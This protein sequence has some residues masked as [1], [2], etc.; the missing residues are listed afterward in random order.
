MEC[1]LK[2]NNYLLYRKTDSYFTKEILDQIMVLERDFAGKVIE[3][4]TSEQS[5]SSGDNIYLCGDIYGFSLPIDVNIFIIEELSTYNS[6]NSY[7][8]LVKLGEVPINI[9]N[10]G[11]LCRQVF[12]N[13]LFEKIMEKHCF[14]ELTESNKGTV[15]LRQGIYLS[16]VNTYEKSM[17][18]NLLRCSTNLKGPTENFRETDHLIINKTNELAKRFFNNPAKLNHVLAQVYRNK[19]EETKEKRAGIKAH[20]DKTKDMNENGLMAFVS[21]YDGSHLTISNVKQSGYDFVY[22]KE[23]VLSSLFFKLKKDVVG[24]YKSEFNVVLYPGSVLF[25]PL[26]TNRIYTHETKTSVLPI[27]KIPERMGY[28]VRCSKTV[29]R[30]YEEENATY[31]VNGEKEE[32]MHEMTEDEIELIRDLYFKENV[33]SEKVSYPLILSSMNSG[34]YLK[35]II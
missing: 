30:Y 4:S 1:T 13:N 24:E 17:E 3:I 15:S 7:W 33:Y 10:V 21:F 23:S 29:A 34:D 2:T 19:M 11:V 6:L 26:S 20:S 16:N 12:S 32:K 25:I 35:P 31:I 28:V 27:S 14:Q 8:K 18:F 9:H 5:F 22:N